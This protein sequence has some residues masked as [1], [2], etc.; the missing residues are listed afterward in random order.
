[1]NRDYLTKLLAAG[2]FAILLTLVPASDAAVAETGPKVAVVA[3]GLFGDQ[4]VFESEAKGAAAIV[5]NRFG[6]GPVTVRANTRRRSDATAE[7]LAASL[8]SVAK[9]IDAEHDILVL[10]L[11]SHG[12]R[13]GLAVKAGAREETLSPWLLASTLRYSGVRHRVVIISACYSGIFLPLADAD[14]MVITAA[15][16]NH[17]SFGCRDG[18]QWT[19]FGDAF[20]NT[21]MRRATNLREAFNQ[22]RDLVRRRELRNGFDPSNPQMAGGENIEPVLVSAAPTPLPP[23]K[24]KRPGAAPEISAPGPRP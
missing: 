3:F 17:P 7:T 10:I 2:L 21:A 13:G 8:D 1:M 6:R 11:T 16:A 9:E 18:A 15:D 14:T 19:Y 12:S 4:S 23:T 24:G 22:A 5:A 20:F